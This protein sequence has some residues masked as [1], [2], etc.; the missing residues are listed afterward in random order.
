MSQI[1]SSNDVYRQLVEEADESW[2]YGLVCFAI[3]E[4]QRIEWMKHF[5]ENNGNSPSTQDIQHWYEQQPEGVLLRAKGTAENALQLY[6][7][8]V[9]Q[10]ILETER[11]EVA[12]SV[13]VS[14]V[15]LIRRF[16]PLFG[17]NV[18]AGFAS[19]LL[20]AAVLVVLA[21]V[22]LTDVSPVK[23]GQGIFGHQSEESVNGETDRKPGSN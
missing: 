16:W 17:I 15:R 12:E 11:R 7:D 22:V 6:A 1:V 13:I 20:F 19:A 2:L 14:E 3:V 18:A 10:E 4:E 23:L 21:L 8:L 5:E 9:L